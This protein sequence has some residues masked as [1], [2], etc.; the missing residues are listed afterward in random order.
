M[1]SGRVARRC[2]RRDLGVAW[3]GHAG[4]ATA[5]DDPL[6]VT[7]ALVSLPVSRAAPREAPR[8]NKPCP[9]PSAAL[10]PTTWVLNLIMP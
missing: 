9:S 4:V 7:P 6:H 3:Q 10:G 8:P 1:L 2:P 5:P